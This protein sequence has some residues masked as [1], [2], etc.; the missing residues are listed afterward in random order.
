MTT[1]S[2]D[3]VIE[4]RAQFPALAQLFQGEPLV[5]LD[6]PAG[7]QVPQRVIDAM[8][9]YFSTCNANHGGQFPTSK[10]SDE[11]VD[12]GHEAFAQFVGAQD[13]REIIFGQNMTSLTFALSRSLA[14]TW[15]AGDEIIVTRLDHDANVSPWIRAARDA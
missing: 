14:K 2:Q 5:Y 7:T 9:R 15:N 13:G 4:L 8:G 3:Q 10:V 1:L 12:R 11:W 6:G